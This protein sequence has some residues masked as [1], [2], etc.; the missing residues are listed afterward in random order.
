MSKRA[1]QVLSYSLAVVFIWFGLL[2][3]AGVSPVVELVQTTYPWLPEPFFIR[4]LGGGELLIGLLLLGKR[5][6]RWGVVLLLLQMLGIFGGLLLHPE[7]Y[8]SSGK[9]YLLTMAGEFV[10]KNLVLL[11]A[12][13]ILWEA[14]RPRVT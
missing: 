14:S 3:L 4:V 1:A 7:I 12:A 2:K 9:P 5:T 10:I 6:R 11:A 13:Y 8:F